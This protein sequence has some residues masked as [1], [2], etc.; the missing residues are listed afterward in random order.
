[1]FLSGGKQPARKLKRV[2]ILL[3][4]EAGVSDEAIVVGFAVSGSS[5]YRT[6]RHFVE[7]NLRRALNE[8]PQSGAERKLTGKEEAIL[9]ATA[10]SSLLA[11]ARPLDSGT[12]GR[13]HGQTDH[14]RQ[15]LPRD[16]A[17]PLAGDD[18]KPWRKDMW[19]IP[20]STPTMSHAWRMFSISLPNRQ[21]RKGRWSVSTKALSSSSV[22]Y[23]SRS[24][25]PGQI[26]RYDCEYRRNGTA[27][28]FVFRPH[29]MDVHNRKG[30]RQ[31]GPSLSPSE[32]QLQATGKE[33]KPLCRGTSRQ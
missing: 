7:G 26:E 24:P 33:S 32:I 3:A 21:T 27:D 29:Q 1:V 19:C 20:Q 31:N 23:A 2:Q 16:G 12:A 28:L 13:R 11:G 6:R 18:L 15:P 8:D 25:K 14:A 9:V 5:V 22:R 4:A 10:F 30:S 17:S